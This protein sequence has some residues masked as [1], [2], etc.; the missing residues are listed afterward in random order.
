MPGFAVDGPLFAR[1]LAQSHGLPP[2][3]EAIAKVDATK[4]AIG[5]QLLMS[6]SVGFACNACHDVAGVKATGVFDEKGVDF[7]YTARRL[8][9]AYYHRWMLNPTRLEPG[10]KMPTFSDKG[11]TPFS[12]VY[13]GDARE[14]FEAIWHYLIQLSSEGKKKDGT[15]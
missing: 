7:V 14:Q 10:T 2:A 15:R 3:A 1:G 13:D 11:K 12:E 8:R 9:N 5:K 6:K 4:A